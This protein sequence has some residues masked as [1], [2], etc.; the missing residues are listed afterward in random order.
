MVFAEV[1]LVV[2]Q[3]LNIT[4]IGIGSGSFTICQVLVIDDI[5]GLTIFPDKK[6]KLVKRFLTGNE[7]PN[8]PK[9]IKKASENFIME[10]KNGEYPM[11][12]HYHQLYE[13]VSLI[14]LLDLKLQYGRLL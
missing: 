3:S 8:N 6:P 4:T 7:N 5:L 12:W 2:T 9:N 1:A 11:P 14:E 13:K 10:V